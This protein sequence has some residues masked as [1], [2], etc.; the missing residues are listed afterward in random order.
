MYQNFRRADNAEPGALS[1]SAAKVQFEYLRRQVQICS[2][3]RLVEQ[4]ASRKGLNRNVAALTNLRPVIQNDRFRQPPP[5]RYSIQHPP[6][7]PAAQRSIDLNGWALTRAIVHHG[8]SLSPC[9]RNHARLAQLSAIT[10][11]RKS[12]EDD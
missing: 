10:V 4:L 12:P 2:F 3:T 1:V 7:S 6:H 9:S 8:Q 11:L 5:R